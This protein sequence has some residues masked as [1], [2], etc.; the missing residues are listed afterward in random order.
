MKPQV[1]CRVVNIK[2]GPV[3]HVGTEVIAD[4][5]HALQGKSCTKRHNATFGR[6]D[7]EVCDFFEDFERP[8]DGS[9]RLEAAQCSC[10][11]VCKC[12]RRS[13]AA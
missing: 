13:V 4:I 10:E 7:A 8:R 9:E 3:R 6:F 5:L 11:V 1:L 12:A 2:L